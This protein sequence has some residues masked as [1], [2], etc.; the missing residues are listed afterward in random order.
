MI[1]VEVKVN[2]LMSNQLLE[3][4]KELQ[5]V[6][7]EGLIEFKKLTPVDTGNARRRTTLQGDTIKANYKYAEVLDQ[8]RHSTPRGMRGSDQAPQGMTR[9]FGRWLDAR[10][11][12]IFGK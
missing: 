11:K 4:R 1:D 3:I 2:D 7:A 8:G 12:K 5:R 6:P 10:L 9:P